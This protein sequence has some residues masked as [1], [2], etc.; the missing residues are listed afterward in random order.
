MFAV[1]SGPA[2]GAGFC[3]TRAKRTK[4]KQYKGGSFFS[5]APDTQTCQ[6]AYALKAIPDPENPDQ[7]TYPAFPAALFGDYDRT[8][9]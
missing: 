3:E 9:C 5:W 7:K 2:A 1:G 4:T 8:A 6:R